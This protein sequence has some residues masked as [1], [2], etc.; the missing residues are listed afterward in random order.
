MGEIKKKLKDNVVHQK[1]ASKEKE[2]EALSHP[3]RSKPLRFS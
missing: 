2:G 1:K 3:E